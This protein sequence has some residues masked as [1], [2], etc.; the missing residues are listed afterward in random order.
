MNSKKS[1]RKPWE[2]KKWNN[3]IIKPSLEKCA[4]LIIPGIGGLSPIAL[5]LYYGF[6]MTIH[7]ILK[8]GVI[9]TGL[10]GLV[11]LYVAIIGLIKAWH[12]RGI[13][14]YMKTMPGVIG[15]KMSGQLIL[16]A[17]LIFDKNVYIQLANVEDVSYADDYLAEGSPPSGKNNC[18]YRHTITIDTDDLKFI[19]G[20]CLISVKF[21]I[22]YDTKD[23]RDSHEI[24]DSY[25]GTWLHEYSWYL[26]VYADTQ[27]KVNFDISFT[28]PIFR[29]KESDPSIIRRAK[30]EEKDGQHFSEVDMSCDCVRMTQ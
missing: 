16:P 9:I 11:F 8:V 18:L 27:K 24:P 17:N 6:F 30:S 15:G 25:C 4:W 3:G 14:F 13:R 22:P 2:R 12:A 28:V 29:T 21:T 5:C 23:E 7:P 1:S 20:K 19:G 26:R 10:T